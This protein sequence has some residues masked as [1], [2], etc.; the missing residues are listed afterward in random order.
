MAPP[1]STLAW[2]IPW[3][4]EPGRL[5]SMGSQRVGHD[6]E[7]E[8]LH[9]HLRAWVL[10]HISRVGLFVRLLCPW[11]SPGKNNGMGYYL[12]L[13]GIFPT[14]GLNPHLLCLLHW[15]AGSLPAEDWFTCQRLMGSP[16]VNRGWLTLPGKPHYGTQ[17]SSTSQNNFPCF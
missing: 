6:W 16:P 14:Q 12:L 1:S 9:F 3:I 4:E 17:L 11:D 8:W 7:T 10:S 2:K 15:Q 13:Q 5:P